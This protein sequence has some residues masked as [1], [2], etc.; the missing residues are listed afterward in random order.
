MEQ[1][2]FTF[3]RSFF[4]AISNLPKASDR[5]AAMMAL[6][7][8]ALNGNERPLSGAAA[9]VFMLVKPNLDH[10]RKK[11][12]NG[13]KGGRPKAETEPDDTYNYTSENEEPNDNL[14]GT[15][16]EPNAKQTGVGGRRQE[17][18]GRSRE[19]GDIE[20]VSKSI[21]PTSPSY[22]PADGSSC[23]EAGEPAPPPE[24]KAPQKK[25]VDVPFSPTVITL[26]LNDHTEHEV[27]QCDLDNWQELFPGVD[28]MQEL[29]SMKAWCEGNP[30]LR[31]TKK[32]IVRFI[33]SW[34][35]REQ[36]KSST[37][38]A[39]APSTRKYQTAADYKAENNVPA[40]DPM[41]D[42]SARLRRQLERKQEA[43]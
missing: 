8:Y 34:L 23:A 9:A 7:D 29:R 27:T 31:K 2:S 17:V 35:M 5:D 39:S 16:P 11:H 19:L 25:K 41:R 12:E 26:V 3:Y 22:P 20:N 43:T 13:L 42:D 37:R 14:T 10:N 24:A 21:P 4:E 6:C 15:K 30:A 40:A 28:V 18:G 36:N 32:G 38:P 33:V 1:I